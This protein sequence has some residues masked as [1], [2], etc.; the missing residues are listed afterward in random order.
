MI[1]KCNEFVYLILNKCDNKQSKNMLSEVTLIKNVLE[2]TSPMFVDT[3][4]LLACLTMYPLR[5]T[6]R[7]GNIAAMVSPCFAASSIRQHTN[8]SNNRQLFPY[9]SYVW[10][11]IFRDCLFSQILSFCLPLRTDVTYKNFFLNIRIMCTS[12]E[13]W[14]SYRRA[15]WEAT[16]V[17]IRNA[18]S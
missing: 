10:T 16:Y 3:P 7:P 15:S 13:N 8:V 4:I 14:T 12:K 11:P 6:S 1:K 18:T 9:I 2:I 17:F 5:T